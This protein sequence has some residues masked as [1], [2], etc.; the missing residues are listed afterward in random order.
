MERLKQR[1][2]LAQDFGAVAGAITSR[3]AV[4]A[5]LPEKVPQE[6]IAQIL[7]AAARAPS[8]SNIQPWHVDVVTGRTR[9][10]LTKA[11][12]KRFDAGDFGEEAYQYYPTLGANPTLPVVGPRAG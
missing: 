9:D 12:S 8:G 2:S 4:R 10:S 3:R 6:T 11:I 7:E 1:R 5:F